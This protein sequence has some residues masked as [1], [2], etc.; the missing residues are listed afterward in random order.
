[1][2][3]HYNVSRTLIYSII[4]IL[5]MLP[6]LVKANTIFEG[7]LV[8]SPCQID[9]SSNSINVDFLDIPVK[10][11][12]FGDGKGYIEK[13]DIKLI[14]CK[15][16][17]INK[18]VKLYFDGREDGSLSGYLAVDG[19]NDKK[20]AIGILDTDGVSLLKLKSAHNNG[21]GTPIKNGVITLS[22]GAF[23]QATPEA[24]ANKTVVPSNYSAVAT[25][26]LIYS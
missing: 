4:A 13:F 18:E 17:D 2:K 23:I 21:N 3:N 26:S 24:L 5:L 16:S 25:F 22:F 1:M 7:T 14:N 20:L 8:D 15:P 19:V 12:H 11:F 6:A 10:N 9:P